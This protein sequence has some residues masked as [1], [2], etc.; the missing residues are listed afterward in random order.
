M[1]IKKATQT[2]SE[3]TEQAM[4]LLLF[5]SRNKKANLSAKG[6]TLG[7][8]FT[9]ENDF[10][11]KLFFFENNDSNKQVCLLFNVINAVYL[12]YNLKQD[13]LYTCELLWRLPSGLPHFYLVMHKQQMQ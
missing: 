13:K 10:V 6:T 7:E 1:P 8:D 11:S 4:K 3:N 12:Q 9:S 2:R 5:D